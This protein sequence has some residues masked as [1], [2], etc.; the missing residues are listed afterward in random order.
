MEISTKKQLA[1]I[2]SQLKGFEEPKAKLEQYEIDSEIAAEVV[3]NAFYRRE[4]K[5]KV[6]ADLGC[7]TGIL[8]LSTLLMGAKKVYFVDIDGDA[9]DIAK[10]NIGFLEEKTGKKL[11]DKAEFVVSDIDFFDEKVDLIVENPPF[12]IKGDK[13]ADK[14]F[15][16]KAF[17]IAEV[18]YSFHKAESKQFIDAVAKDNGFEVE[19][20][21]EFRWPLKQ[22]MEYHKKKVEYIPV[23]CWRLVKMG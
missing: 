9:L 22:T 10:E 2:L 15:L 5:G 16:E 11:A 17:K 18:I 12:G 3:W 6:V 8:G 13:H 23:G 14:V 1:V 4:I 20:Y 21:W 19:G 7:G